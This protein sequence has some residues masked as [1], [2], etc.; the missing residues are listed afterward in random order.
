MPVFFCSI[1]SIDPFTPPPEIVLSK[2][3]IRKL[4]RSDKKL[5]VKAADFRIFNISRSRSIDADSEMLRRR[6]HSGGSK[7]EA[8]R[9]PL[10]VAEYATASCMQRSGEANATQLSQGGDVLLVEKL[11]FAEAHSQIVKSFFLAEVG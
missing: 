11:V 1:T 5:D 7:V 10:E 3:Q 8:S 6:M 4:R 2:H 9:H